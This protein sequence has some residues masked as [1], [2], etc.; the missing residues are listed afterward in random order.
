MHY[1]ESLVL[2]VCDESLRCASVHQ[3]LN[4]RTSPSNSELRVSE[5]ESLVSTLAD[6]SSQYGAP[7]VASVESLEG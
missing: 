4:G 1:M 3:S 6:S 5:T 2:R 7:C